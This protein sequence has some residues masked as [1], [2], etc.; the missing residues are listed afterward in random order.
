MERFEQQGL[1]AGFGHDRIRDHTPGPVNERIDSQTRARLAEVDQM[2]P[3]QVGR[4]LAELDY[5]WDVDR[6]LM[7]LFPLLGGASFSLGLRAVS[8]RKKGNGWLYLFGTQLAFMMLHAVAGWCPPVSVL[9]RLGFRTQREIA[10]ERQGLSA[11]AGQA[12]F[13]AVSH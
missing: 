5:E 1:T 8:G 3:V 6:T 12:A 2:G 7:A 4:R 9:R 10:L 13:P 11:R